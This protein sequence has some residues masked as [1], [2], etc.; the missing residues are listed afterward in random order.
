M[1]NSCTQTPVPP[2]ESE[3]F[4]ENRQLIVTF[5]ICFPLHL[6]GISRDSFHKRRATGGK[7]AQIRKKRKYELGR[8]A[9]N[10]KVRAANG[11]GKSR[12]PF[13][14][15]KFQL[16]FR[17]EPSASTLCAPV[18]ETANSARSVSKVETLRGHRRAPLARLASS[19]SSTTPPTTSSSVP[20]HW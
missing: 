1:C 6:T 15:L 11:R 12:F 20:R 19:T 14:N 4:V 9:A 13:S 17:S 18:E 16:D 10:T 2:R 7:K 5:S 3:S 8:P